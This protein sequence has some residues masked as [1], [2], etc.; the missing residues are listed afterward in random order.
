MTDPAPCF[1]CQSPGTTYLTATSWVCQAHA[2]G[3][4]TQYLQGG[5]T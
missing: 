1:I 3:T 5:D 4:G 2:D